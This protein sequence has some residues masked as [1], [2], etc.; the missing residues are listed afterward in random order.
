MYSDSIRNFETNKI[1]GG[2]GALLTAI[3]SLVLFSGAVGIVGIVGIILVLISMR[4][5][6]DDFKDILIFRRALTG[7]VFG[8]IGVIIAIAVLSAFGF[9]TG[10]I[11]A[12]PVVGAF[13]LLLAIVAWVTMYV[14]LILASVYFKQSFDLL[15]GKSNEGLLRIGGLI[16]LIG[17]ALTI[18]FVGFFLMFIGWLLIAVGLFLMRPPMQQVPPTYSA[19]PSPAP[20]APSGN[21]R[22]C[23]NCGAENRIDATFCTHCGKRLT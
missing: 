1:L 13:G 7:F 6:A 21:I 22:Y 9:L 3:G 12:H 2:V 16:L 10:F 15:A 5:L 4:G 20:A 19:P 18:I 11:F 17:G 14:F 8:I 23:S